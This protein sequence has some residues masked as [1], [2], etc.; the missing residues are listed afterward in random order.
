M[1]RSSP[2]VPALGP[3]FHIGHAICARW[4]WGGEWLATGVGMGWL[5]QA[6][7]GWVERGVAWLDW[8]A[9]RTGRRAEIP[10]HLLTGL[11]GEDAAL[12]YLQRK[13]YT[14]VARRWS[15]GNLRG[16]LDLVAWKGPLLCVV[17]VKTRTAHDLTAAEIAVDDH[18]RKMVRRLARAY[19]RQLPLGTAPPV[20]FDVV[21]VYL[22]EGKAAE[23]QHFEGSFGWDEG[24]GRWD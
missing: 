6:R 2:P 17:E 10:E 14:V 3:G 5:A 15:A 11:A 23:F 13:G 9:Q 22:L 16:D 4:G 19:V 24:E 1:E 21:S 18:K 20:R 12:F 7:I 8:A